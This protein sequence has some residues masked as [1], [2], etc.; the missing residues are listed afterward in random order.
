MATLIAVNVGMPK[1]IAW[2]GKTVHTGIWK[3]PSPGW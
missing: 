3:S 2:H 1:D